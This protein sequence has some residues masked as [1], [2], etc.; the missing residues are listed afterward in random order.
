M[1]R[2]LLYQVIWQTDALTDII[3]FTSGG[4]NKFVIISFVL[5]VLILVR[6][7]VT[8]RHLA[9]DLYL[10]LPRVNLHPINW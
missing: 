3:K 5:D 9:T 2:A 10:Y 4:N 7:V 8:I 1:A 6:K